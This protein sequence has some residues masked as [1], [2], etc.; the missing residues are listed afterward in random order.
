MNTGKVI[1]LAVAAAALVALAY[2]TAQEEEQVVRS[3]AAPTVTVLDGLTSATVE[4]IEIQTPDTTAPV[5]LTKKE[6]T[7]YTDVAKGYRADK[8][9]INGVFNTL[10]GKL[11]G[12]VV[13]SNPDSFPDYAVDEKSGT[14]VKFVGAGDKMLADLIIGKD[15]P[16]SFTTYVRKADDK[17]IVNANKS[18]SY[19]FKKPDGWR[20]RTIL[21][22]G[23]DAITAV[24]AEGTSATWTLVKQG[25]TWK[26]TEPVEREAQMGKVT[27][28]LSSLANLRATE[29]VDPET[30]DAL[31][32][33]GLDPPRQKLTI[34]HEDRSTSPAQPVRTVL[35]LGNPRGDGPGNPYY[36]KR[37][38]EP[39]VA[40]I[41]E[42]QAQMISPAY[43]EIAVIPAPPPPPPVEETT[44]TAA[45][46]AETTA[47]AATEETTGMPET[48]PADSVTTASESGEA[49]ASESQAA[50]PA[51]AAS[52]SSDA[53]TTGPAETS[54]SET[55]AAP[56]PTPEP[57]PAPEAS[58]APSTSSAAAETTTV[59][60]SA[61]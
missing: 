58:D 44:A 5:V 15:G 36:V 34:T 22:F 56:A 2:Y 10:N 60:A 57:V 47:A 7:W 45:S 3:A 28:L 43:E 32:T 26:V 20:D 30:T 24:K 1:G 53:E 14:R 33:F 17:Q 46:A 39:G 59:T 23:S 29:F 37:A 11:E 18:L 21:D 49:S 16:A 25:D 50:A 6:S 13:S 61:G 12:E 40:L 52:A 31:A 55:E 51:E 8:N 19:V 35:L 38:E 4:R 48:D 41:N 42:Y 54:P 27:P 9:L